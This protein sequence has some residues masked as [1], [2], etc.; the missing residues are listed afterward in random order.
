MQEYD[1]FHPDKAVKY[2]SHSASMQAGEDGD[3]S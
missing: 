2:S 1:A 3:Q